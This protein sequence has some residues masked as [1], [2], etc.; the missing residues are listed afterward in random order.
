M[1]ILFLSRWFPYPPDN[2]SK[3]RIINLIKYLSS[4]HEVHLISFSSDTVSEQRLA[5]MRRYCRRVETVPY[6][7]FQPQGPKALAGYLSRWPRSALDTYSRDLQ[8]MVERAEQESSIEL[9]IASQIDMVRYPLV[10]P[11]VPRLLEE[12][13]LTPV[14]EQFAGQRRLPG[15]LRAQMTWCKLSGYVAELLPAFEACTVVS[16]K[17]RERVLAVL[18]NY[19]PIMVVPNGIDV[20]GHSSDFGSPV[21]DTLVYA[22]ALTYQPNF[23]A[24]DFFMREILPMILAKRPKVRLF[25][26]G[27]LDGVPRGRLP[28]TDNV[29]FTGYLEDVRPTVARSWVS[30]AP[31]RS[32]GGTRLKI[33]ESL[34]LGTPVVATSKG[35]E[36]LDLTRGDDILI[37][38]SPTDFAAAV[39]RILQDAELRNVLSQHGR[40]AVEA[41][42]DWRTI[43]PT[44]CDFVDRLIPQQRNANPGQLK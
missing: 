25:I 15:R 2:G 7:P 14:Y 43:G 28:H 42:Y 23:A 4:R 3:I 35:A 19:Q 27:T 12:L 44:F 40:Q 41:K 26:T 10:L 5:A 38:D 30:I 13:E 36:G 22:G 9:V 1:A 37:A 33:L 39:L 21:A 32:G 18:P 17:E 34:V 8:R 20:S 6:R 16:Q 29:V 31:L 24:V 11:K